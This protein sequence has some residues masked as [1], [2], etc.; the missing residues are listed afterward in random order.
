MAIL[1]VAAKANPALLLPTI[2]VA[3]YAGT[4]DNSSDIVTEI[5][6]VERLGPE[7]N[8]LE[9]KTPYG[10]SVAGDDVLRHLRSSFPVD[11]PKVELVRK[12]GAW[13]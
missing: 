7:G 5:E 8:I 4:V 2:L 1:R 12:P 11:G 9:L 13:P 3:A 10:T 6:D